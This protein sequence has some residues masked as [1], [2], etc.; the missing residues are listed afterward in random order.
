[1]KRLRKLVVF[2]AVLLCFSI[3]VHAD[4]IIDGGN[5]DTSVDYYVVVS[6]SDGG[7]NFRYGAGAEYDK[8]ISN[9]IPNGTVLHIVGE[10]AANTGRYWGY[11]EY[12]GLWGYVALSQ[13]ASYEAPKKTEPFTGGTAAD[14]NISINGKGDTANLR[15]GP[16]VE[17]EKAASSAIPDGTVLHV[18][19]EAAAAN[20]NSWG[21]VEYNGAV[22]W[23]ALNLA[24]KT[25]A[26]TAAQA[27]EKEQE[28]LEKEAKEQEALRKEAK[29]QEALEK[30]AK[31]Q[32]ALK[33]K[34]EKQKA[35]DKKN[36]DDADEENE[37]DDRDKSAKDSG[38][39]NG[40]LVKLLVAVF[41]CLIIAATAG[42]LIVYYKNHKTVNSKPVDSK[43]MNSKPEGM[44]KPET[45][46]G[47]EVFCRYC[48]KKNGSANEFC[49]F[50]GK[51]LK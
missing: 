9:M 25:E 1:M 30:E 47:G 23:V 35:E 37:D 51:K 29:E 24:E 39:D 20:G 40:F 7:A 46:E 26:L 33:E 44:K 18:E 3:P 13:T 31:E 2:L 42:F 34:E 38:M 32:E 22:G 15:I 45:K 14:Y 27:E 10:R 6:A 11:T 41:V 36:S 4:A 50:C 28:A 19:K 43:P 21:Q 8:L 17:Y 48:G 12:Q 5:S 16:G 49:R